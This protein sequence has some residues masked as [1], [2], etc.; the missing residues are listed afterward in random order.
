M[1][2]AVENKKLLESLKKNGYS[3][4]KLNKNMQNADIIIYESPENFSS[5]SMSV[6][7]QSPVLM[8]NS[9]GKS[10]YEIEYIIKTRLYSPLF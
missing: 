3:A 5:N 8:I 10:L 2:I 9:L 1:I 4:V 7:F 6:G